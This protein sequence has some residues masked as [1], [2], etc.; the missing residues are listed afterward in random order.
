MRLSN[1]Y[2]QV[3]VFIL[4]KAVPKPRLSII[5]KHVYIACTRYLAPVIL[6]S[7]RVFLEHA[8]LAAN[9]RSGCGSGRVWTALVNPMCLMLVELD[10]AKKIPGYPAGT[11]T[12]SVLVFADSGNAQI[13]AGTKIPAGVSRRVC[14]TTSADP[15]SQ[16]SLQ[17]LR[18]KDGSGGVMSV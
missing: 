14:S 10:P 1:T 5:S 11:S 9:P 2:V 16:T 8:K 18:N 3:D 17:H 4:E 13:T 7:A 12:T 6:W 15:R